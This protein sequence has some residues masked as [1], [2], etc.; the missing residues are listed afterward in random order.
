MCSFGFLKLWEFKASVVG[1][2]GAEGLKFR[3]ALS[4]SNTHKTVQPCQL[5]YAWVLVNGFKIRKP[6]YLV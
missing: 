3:T 1:R 6:Y 5:D 2:R 4:N